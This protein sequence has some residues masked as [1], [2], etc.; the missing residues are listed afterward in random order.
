MVQEKKKFSPFR[1]YLVN[2]IFFLLIL[3]AAFLVF[4]I[5]ACGVQEVEVKGATFYTDQQI[6]HL[7]L[8]D[9]YRTNGAWDVIKNRV[10]PR[11]DIPFV[12]DVKVGLKNFHK[13]TITVTEKEITGYI[14]TPDGKLIY[15]DREG[16]VTDISHKL[17]SGMI[18]VEGLTTKKKIVEGKRYP[19]AGN[20]VAALSLIFRS[21][22]NMDLD[23]NSISFG[24][25]GQITLIC[26]KVTVMLG[27]ADNLKD[28]LLR[29]SY[30]LPKVGKDAGTL[31]FENYTS[32]NT[33]IV[34]DAE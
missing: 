18:P 1:F 22:D 25:S 17:L 16:T 13:L 19:A 28:K 3:V 5:L 11:K 6:E 2:F 14:T 34:F 24:D 20:R 15:L 33:D 21:K 12:S 30:I 27:T 23:I 10:H 29:L 26:G 32:D 31:H 9:R 4:L 8:N 7:V